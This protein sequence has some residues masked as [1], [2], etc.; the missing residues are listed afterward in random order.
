MEDK[1]GGSAYVSQSVTVVSGTNTGTAPTVAEL[2]TATINE[3]DTYSTTGSFADP[4]AGDS[5]TATV[6]YGDGSGNQPLVL[7]ADKTF[8]LSH[9]YAVHGGFDVT[10][11]VTDSTGL[12]GTQTTQ[13]TVNNVARRL[14]LPVLCPS[15]STPSSASPDRS[16]T[17]ALMCQRH[18]QLWRWHRRSSACS[19][20]QQDVHAQPHVSI[21]WSVQRCCERY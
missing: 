16:P 10:V 13:V 1:N 4:D 15:Q 21:R 5:W 9:V 14:H 3:G 2:A 7:N 6:N 20:R 12:T 17:P 11:T 19:F 8:D 18:R